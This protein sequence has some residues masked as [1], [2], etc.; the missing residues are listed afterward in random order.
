MDLF[1]IRIIELEKYEK[2][3]NERNIHAKNINF[4]DYIK[5]LFN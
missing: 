5:K 1:I 4:I 3:I 2:R